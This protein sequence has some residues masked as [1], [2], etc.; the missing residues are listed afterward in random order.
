MKNA[1]VI[2]RLTPEQK[3]ALQIKAINESTTVQALLERAVEEIVR[4]DD[5]K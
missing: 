2:F 1:P 4:E 3:K 5:E